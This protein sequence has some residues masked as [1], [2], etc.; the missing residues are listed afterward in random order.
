MP[1]PGTITPEPDPVEVE[2]DAALP[3]RISTVMPGWLVLRQAST[4]GRKAELTLG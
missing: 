4:G 2:S 3:S 1:V